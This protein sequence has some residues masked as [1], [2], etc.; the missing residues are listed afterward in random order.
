MDFLELPPPP[1]G[2]RLAIILQPAA[3]ARREQAELEVLYQLRDRRTAKATTLQRVALGLRAVEEMT[4]AAR[5][6]PVHRLRQ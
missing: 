1:R 5:S 4:Q 2:K 6:Y 3:E